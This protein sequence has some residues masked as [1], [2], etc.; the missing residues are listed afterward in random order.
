MKKIK[1]FSMD[2][3]S[4]KNGGKPLTTGGKVL[5]IAMFKQKRPSFSPA[6]NVVRHGSVGN[7]SE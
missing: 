6:D 4:I 7:Y 2:G 3:K 5:I 1:I